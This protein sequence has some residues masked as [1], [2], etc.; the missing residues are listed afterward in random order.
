MDPLPCL[1]LPSPLSSPPPPSL[2]SYFPP[3]CLLP[4][5]SSLP[6]SDLWRSRSFCLAFELCTGSPGH[7]REAGPAF[8]VPSAVTPGLPGCLTRC[9]QLDESPGPRLPT[10]HGRPDA[11]IKWCFG[12]P[13]AERPSEARLGGLPHSSAVC[14]QKGSRVDPTGCHR[15]PRERLDCSF[16]GEEV[17]DCHVLPLSCDPS[18][19]PVILKFQLEWPGRRGPRRKPR[20]RILQ[21]L[22]RL[23]V[24]SC[25]K[26]AQNASGCRWAW[27]STKV[28]TLVPD[29]S[30]SQAIGFQLLGLLRAQLLPASP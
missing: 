3:C 13:R 23:K 18:L 9:V 27:D 2:P 30:P 7:P 22:L 12:S 26:S 21:P 16:Q 8:P 1:L 4:P 10:H 15:M 28:L 20:H 6:S 17:V 24:P 25:P 14:F 5:C 19:S 11:A 29:M